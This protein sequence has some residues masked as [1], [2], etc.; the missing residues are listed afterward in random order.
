MRPSPVEIR[1]FVVGVPRSGTTLA[2]S[3][4]AAHSAMTSFTESHFFDKHFT[5]RPPLTRPILTRDPVPRL[6]AFLAENDEEPPPAAAWFESKSRSPL[7]AR[8][9]MPLWTLSTARQFLRVLDEVAL[10]RGSSCWI[11]KTPRHLPYIPFLEKAGQGGPRTSF[12][13][14]IRDGLEVV[15]SLHEASKSWERAYDLDVCVERWNADVALS[16]ARL[17][18]PADHFI[19]YEELTSQP[20][21]VMSRTIEWLGLS[22]EPEILETYAQ[23]SSRLVTTEEAWKA[24]VGRQIRRSGTADQVLTADQ[25]RRVKS[26]LR[27]DLYDLL[28]KRANEASESV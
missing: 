22:W 3:L 16:A 11:E 26:S 20:E 19:L 8:P 27:H 2:Q 25:R 4:L 10:R 18:S 7:W 17:T 23:A 5:L 12:V 21:A 28:R 9:L 14:V 6:R 1:V 24:D 13:H 15:A